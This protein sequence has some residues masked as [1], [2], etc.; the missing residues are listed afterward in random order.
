MAKKD[1]L[2]NAKEVL[3]NGTAKEKISYLWYYFKWHFLVLIIVIVMAADLIY[4]NIT[5]KEYVLQGMFLN[6]LAEQDI[7]LELEKVFAD[8]RCIGIA[9]I[10]PCRLSHCDSYYDLD[11]CF[12]CGYHPDKSV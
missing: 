11:W 10:S 5:A 3:K 6:V 7:S 2:K 8:G 1:S 12:S 4:T 9:D